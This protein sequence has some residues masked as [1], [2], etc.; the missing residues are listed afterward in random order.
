MQ[1]LG[2]LSEKP[3]IPF[4]THIQGV[5]QENFPTEHQKCHLQPKFRV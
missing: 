5:K 4:A 2:E 1:Q 3:K